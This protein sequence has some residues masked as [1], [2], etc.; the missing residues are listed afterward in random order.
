MQ[1]RKNDHQRR[2]QAGTRAVPAMVSVDSLPKDLR[3]LI[4]GAIAGSASRT[5]VS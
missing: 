3:V 2:A 1:S 5:S 4:A